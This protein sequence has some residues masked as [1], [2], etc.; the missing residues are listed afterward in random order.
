MRLTFF[1]FTISFFS[2]TTHVP[3]KYDVIFENDYQSAKQ[4]I[5]THSKNFQQTSNK[6]KHHHLFTTAI[7]FPELMRYSYLKDIVE[8][9]ALEL[10]Y[11]EYGASAA[12]FSIGHFQMKPSFIES[13]ETEI[14]KSDSLSYLYSNLLMNKQLTEKQ[15]RRI[16]LER[17]NNVEWQINYLHAFIAVCDELFKDIEFKSLSEKLIIYSTAYNSGFYQSMTQLKIKSGNKHFP[18]GP[19][20]Q[21]TQYA[22]S[23]IAKYYFFYSH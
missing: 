5:I 20:Y 6:Y 16:R 18:F 17:L 13:L 22:Y 19:K 4:F 1:I 3:E 11:V 10:V 15:K 2:F 12:D 23:D 9:T 8:S 21:G 14:S 7:I